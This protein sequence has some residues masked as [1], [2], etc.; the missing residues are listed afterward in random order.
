MQE[1][2]RSVGGEADVVCVAKVIDGRKVTDERK[3]PESI[4]P[5]DAVA[6]MGGKLTFAA[7]SG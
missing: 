3:R 6:G 7:A 1:I 4:R 2:V 5:L